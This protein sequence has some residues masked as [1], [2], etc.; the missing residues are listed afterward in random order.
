MER[1]VGTLAVPLGFS[2]VNTSRSTDFPL[3]KAAGLKPPGMAQKVQLCGSAQLQANYCKNKQTHLGK[4]DDT[5]W[6]VL[7]G[8]W[9]TRSSLGAEL[10]AAIVFLCEG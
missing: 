3:F 8:L 7:Q 9:G 4:Q 6:K 5:A 1:D 10:A 2:S